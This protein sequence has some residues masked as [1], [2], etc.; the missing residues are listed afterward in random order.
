MGGF[1]PSGSACACLRSLEKGKCVDRLPGSEV[2]Q[3]IGPQTATS[4]VTV[5]QETVTGRSNAS[6]QTDG[7]ALCRGKD[8]ELGS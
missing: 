4:E 2:T 6:W 7:E 1:L 3:F 5:G 8:R